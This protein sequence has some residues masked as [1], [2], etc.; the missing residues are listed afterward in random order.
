MRNRSK[1]VRAVRSQGSYSEK[2]QWTVG[3][4]PSKEKINHSLW[5]F[6]LLGLAALIFSKAI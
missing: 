4:K 3:T 6:I 5:A 2:V 1:G